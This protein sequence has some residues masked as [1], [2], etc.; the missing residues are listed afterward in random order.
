[1]K[2]GIF[3]TAWL[4]IMFGILGLMLGLL[5]SPINFNNVTLGAIV[6]IWGGLLLWY[7]AKKYRGGAATMIG[8]LILGLAIN[9]LLDHFFLALPATLKDA[10]IQISIVILLIL[11]GTA[12]LKQGHKMHRL[13]DERATSDT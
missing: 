2:L 8:A 6:I 11:A 9:S 12:L 7:R 13:T 1:M 10:L 5:D 3:L 4:M